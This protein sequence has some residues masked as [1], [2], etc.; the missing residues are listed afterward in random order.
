VNASR[1]P[2]GHRTEEGAARLG[3][4]GGAAFVE[5][6]A[7]PLPDGAAD[8]EIARPGARRCIRNHLEALNDAESG[9]ARSSLWEA[10]TP[11]S[12]LVSRDGC[13][14]IELDERAL[15]ARLEEGR[16]FWLDLAAP[17]REEIGLLAAALDLHPLAVEDSLHFDQRPKL[18][19]YDDF[20]LLVVYGYAPDADGLAEVHCY[21]SDRFLVTVHRDEAPAL[22]DFRRRCERRPDLAGSPAAL[23]HGVL[24]LLADSFFDPVARIDERLAMVEDAL[25]EG[26]GDVHVRDVF[27]MRRRLVTF[28]NVVAAQRDVLAALE[29]SEDE[30][31]GVTVEIARSFRDV[32]DHLVRLAEQIDVSRELMSAAVDAYMSASSNRMSGVMKQ[33]TVIATIFLPLSFITGFFGQNFSWLVEHVGSLAAFLA[34]G[35]GLEL[36]TVAVLLLLFKKRGWF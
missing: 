4:D 8:L 12:H 9:G 18:D 27:A 20:V 1:R 19:E 16:P 13:S 36:L 35:V 23:L 25:L 10:V 7:V 5:A 26:R 15:A 28:R 2:R 6:T 24:D 3:P 30:L 14:E 11:S 17:A 31:P 34:L 29:R 32:H 21:W 22:A 33:L